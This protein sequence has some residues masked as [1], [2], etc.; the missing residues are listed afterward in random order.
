[1]TL[2]N[3]C[4]KCTRVCQQY[5]PVRLPRAA[6]CDHCRCID[7]EPVEPRT[8]PH[9]SCCKCGDEMETVAP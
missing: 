2:N 8:R 1:M 4:C 5:T 3:H 9:S 7:V 6:P